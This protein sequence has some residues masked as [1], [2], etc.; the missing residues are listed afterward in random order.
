MMDRSPFAVA[1]AVAAPATAPNFAKDLFIANAWGDGLPMWPA[2]AQRVNWILR[3]AVL[4][5]AHVLG[6][7]PPRGAV[8]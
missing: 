8:V 7:F 5:R 3:G 1:T 4:P 6:K 2:T